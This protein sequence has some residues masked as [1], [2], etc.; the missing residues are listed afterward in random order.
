MNWIR[1][2]IAGWCFHDWVFIEVKCDRCTQQCRKCEK[3][4]ISYMGDHYE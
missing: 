2:L 4:R 3:T 1:K